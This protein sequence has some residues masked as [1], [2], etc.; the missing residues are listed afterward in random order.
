MLL[1]DIVRR[2]ALLNMGGAGVVASY[3]PWAAWTE[4]VF[5]LPILFNY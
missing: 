5:I 3:T 1:V 2:G 4:P